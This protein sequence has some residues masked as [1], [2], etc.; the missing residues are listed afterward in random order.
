LP[1]DDNTGWLGLLWIL[2]A[3]IPVAIGGGMLQ[4]TINSLITKR[5]TPLEIGGI[6]G[7]S[8]AFLS[9]ANAI[10]PLLAGA[11]FQAVGPTALFLVWGG[12]MG[13]LY[14]VAVSRLRPGPEETA[15]PGLARGGS[16]H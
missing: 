12:L 4:P 5:V 13:L 1:S 11:I 7:I 15:A 10:A 16:A 14:L 6:L 9:L 2:V 3:M 8:A